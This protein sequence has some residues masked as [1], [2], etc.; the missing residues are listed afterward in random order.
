LAKPKRGK[1]VVVNFKADATTL[2]QL[3]EL[4]DAAAHKEGVLDG[5]RSYVIRRAIKNEHARLRR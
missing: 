3:D 5:G 4:R 2:Q 1:L